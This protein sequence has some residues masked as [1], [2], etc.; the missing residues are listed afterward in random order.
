[1][2]DISTIATLVTT[3]SVALGVVFALSELHHLTGIRKTEII[4]KIYEK[5]GSKEMVEAVNKAG[6]SKFFITIFDPESPNHLL[7]IPVSYI[8]D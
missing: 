1:M 8:L 6:G 2:A 5:S 3:V 7:R 4:M